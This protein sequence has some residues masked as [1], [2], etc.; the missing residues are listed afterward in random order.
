MHSKEN[1]IDQLKNTMGFTYKS[2]MDYHIKYV[3]LILVIDIHSSTIL[4]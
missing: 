2:S 1:Y 4:S 3:W